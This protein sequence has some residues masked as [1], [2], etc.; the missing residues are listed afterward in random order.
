[1]NSREMVDLTKD[2]IL[3]YYQ[4]DIQP[5]LDHVDDKVLWY[6]PA[7]GQFLSGKQAVLDAWAREK[8]S[9]RFTLENIWVD[10]IS[11]NSTYCEVM[12]SFP[13]TTHYPDGKSITMDQIIH[14]TW[15]ERKTEDKTKV[16]RM[17]VIHISD[18][19][20]K[21]SS[22]NI[23]PVH[24]NEVYPGYLPVIGEGQRLYFRGMDSCDLYFFANT[25]IWVESVTYGRHSILHTT[26]G[27]FQASAS[28]SVL[29]KKHPDFM[30]RC[31]ESYL[32]NPRYITC[33]KRFSVTLSNGKVLPIPEKK[34]TAF[35]KAVHEKW[36]KDFI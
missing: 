2:I 11:S 30:L 4:N 27:D 3:K 23:Y 17:L 15:C 29:E 33:I 8:H 25:I 19:Y 12:V 20:Q 7:K 10:H 5:F 22:D 13:V 35:K 14:I 1:M 32:V 6:G 16:P 28:T 18:L 9:L 24:L 21:H 31:H 34:Y 26:D 36:A